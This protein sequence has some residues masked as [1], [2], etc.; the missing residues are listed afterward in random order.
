MIP[1]DGG[2]ESYL[3]GSLSSRDKR[4]YH[5]YHTKNRIPVDIGPTDGG[6]EER[7]REGE[8]K[9]REFAVE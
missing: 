9:R 3:R 2:G 4:G 5:F 1:T 7:E 6:S 8:K